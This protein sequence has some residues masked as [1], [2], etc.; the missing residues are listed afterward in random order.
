MIRLSITLLVVLSGTLA[1][2][3]V[4]VQQGLGT[5]LRSAQLDGAYE[6]VSETTIL[7][8]PKALTMRIVA[9]EWHGLWFFQGD[10]FSQTIMKRGRL[11]STYPKF[12]R[13]LGYDSSAGTY[14]IDDNT[15]RLRKQIALH[16][17]S[18]GRSVTLAYQIDGDTLTL[19]ET[20][21]PYPED[22]SQGHRTT[23][24]R[25]VKSPP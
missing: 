21:N 10:R 25:R 13:E 24:L 12:H 17:L 22:L 14:V 11:Y 8:K 18:A 7:T 23:I 4:P 2:L 15:I 20:M 19:I 16:P 9:P 1:H 5:D 3:G 6:F